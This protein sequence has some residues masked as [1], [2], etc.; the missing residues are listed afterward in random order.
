MYI[1][2]FRILYAF[3]FIWKYLDYINQQLQQIHFTFEI[4]RTYILM[5]MARTSGKYHLHSDAH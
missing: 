5:L 1:P 4:N 2:M 3:Q